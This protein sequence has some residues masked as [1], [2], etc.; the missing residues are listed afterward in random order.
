MA[1][2]LDLAKRLYDML[3]PWDREETPEAMA[4]QMDDDPNGTIEYLLDLIDDL[5]G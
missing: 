5:R 4:E 1:T 3:D 2:T